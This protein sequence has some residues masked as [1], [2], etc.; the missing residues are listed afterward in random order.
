MPGWGVEIWKT[1]TRRERIICAI[2]TMDRLRNV[3][4]SREGDGNSKHPLRDL[5]ERER[6][7]IS[8]IP[9]DGMVRC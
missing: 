1:S 6:V 9:A 8:C 5:R 3:G 7:P 2:C 4:L